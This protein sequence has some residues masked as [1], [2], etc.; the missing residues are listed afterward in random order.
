MKLFTASLASGHLGLVILVVAPSI[1][2]MQ[3]ESLFS[4]RL[5]KG[6]TRT[7]TFTLDICNEEDGFYLDVTGGVKS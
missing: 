4:S 1:W 6:R 5:L 3:S 2:M 7:A